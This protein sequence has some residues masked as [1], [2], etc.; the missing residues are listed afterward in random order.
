MITM[1]FCCENMKNYN[2]HGVVVY[3]EKYDEYGILIKDGGA[4]YVSIEFCPW[5]GKKLP[6]SKRDL[7]FESLE[8]MGYEEFD[9]DSIP[10]EFKTGEWYFKIK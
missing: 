5:C 1:N 7:W 2:D 10:P 3:V 4:S 8:N 9:D 6:D